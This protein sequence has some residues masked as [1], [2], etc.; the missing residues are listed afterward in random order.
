MV[1][2]ALK[3]DLHIIFEQ[4]FSDDRKTKGNITQA[5]SISCRNLPSLSL[6]ILILNLLEKGEAI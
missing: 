5:V 4:R 6:L 2:N 3:P 1:V